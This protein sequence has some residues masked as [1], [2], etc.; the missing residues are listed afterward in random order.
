MRKLA[1]VR[2]ESGKG[3]RWALGADSK[4]GTSMRANKQTNKQANI[5]LQAHA[6]EVP[7]K[8]LNEFRTRG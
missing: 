3:L 2:E 7:E 6:F 4:V 8:Y 5:V 1:V